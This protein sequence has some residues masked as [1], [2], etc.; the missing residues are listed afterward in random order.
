MKKELNKIWSNLEKM[1]ADAPDAPEW[2]QD[3]PKAE[4]K[5]SICPTTRVPKNYRAEWERPA[6]AVWRSQHKLALS[7]VQK[8][9]AIALV[10]NRGSGKTRLACEVIRDTH[11]NDAHYT[12]AMYLFVRARGSYRGEKGQSEKQIIDEVARCKLLVLDEVQERGNTDW[13]D[14]IL[15]LI[16]DQRYGNGRPT[17]LIG[18]LKPKDLAKSLGDSI[19]SRLQETGGIIE[20]DGPSHRIKNDKA[21]AP[22][23]QENQTNTEK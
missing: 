10:G 16:L 7:A 12:Q 1:Y 3:E 2:E 17:I 18:N 14:R 13:E 15:T 5:N 20:M 11:P 8:G 4:P 19:T 22:P 6:D 9:G 23:R 21:E